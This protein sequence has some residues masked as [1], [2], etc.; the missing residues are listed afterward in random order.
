V[1][2]A[3]AQIDASSFLHWVVGRLCI[4]PERGL[5][6]QQGPTPFDHVVQ[7]MAINLSPA[8]LRQE[9]ISLLQRLRDRN[10]SA[11]FITDNLLELDDE[12]PKVRTKADRYRQR[13]RVGAK[14]SLLTESFD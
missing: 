4:P 9:L 12:G 8:T 7:G 6:H 10:I 11:Q 14:Q 1:G 3:V 13:R 5:R 2:V